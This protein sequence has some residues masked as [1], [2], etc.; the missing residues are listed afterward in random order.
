MAEATTISLVGTSLLAIQIQ[1]IFL[2][3]SQQIKWYTSSMDQ[4][5]QTHLIGTSNHS[6]G[7]L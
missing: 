3:D 4:F 5:T 1:D 2:T 7:N 6:R